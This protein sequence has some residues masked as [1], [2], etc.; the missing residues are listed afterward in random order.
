MTVETKI[1]GLPRQMFEQV[2]KEIQG[3]A[4]PVPEAPRSPRRAGAV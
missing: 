1:L 3:E 2:G 4:A